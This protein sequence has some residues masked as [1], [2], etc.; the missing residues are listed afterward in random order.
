MTKHVLTANRLLDGRV[1]YLDPARRWTEDLAR[2]AT[3]ASADDLDP[4]LAWA[5]TEEAQVVCDPYLI[6]VEAEDGQI[7]ALSARERL[8][9]EGPLAVLE[10][11]GYAPAAPR[12]ARVAVG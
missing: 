4:A 6:K 2:A 3:V 10:R 12:P 11:F 1:V 8:R 9:A 5:R 7:R